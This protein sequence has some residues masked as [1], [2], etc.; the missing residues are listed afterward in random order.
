MFLGFCFWGLCSSC[1]TVS[2]FVDV[3]RIDLQNGASYERYLLDGTSEQIGRMFARSKGVRPSKKLLF[4]AQKIDTRVFIV[5]Y[6][7][8]TCPDC[9]IVV[10]YLERLRN[11]NPQIE[12]R[13]FARDDKARKMLLE[14]TGR[15]RI[16]TV[17]ITDRSG[18]IVSGHYVEYPRIVYDLL[19]KSKTEDERRAYIDDF[20][21]GK[22]DDD[23]QNDL[24]DLID[25]IYK[26]TD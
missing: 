16:P 15:N 18:R 22:Y 21:A 20:R 2:A 19:E 13:Y 6:G 8:I 4:A 5:I 23:V 7:S 11:A 25:S 14:R 1:K 9:A 10:P 26:A 24:A 17:F 12:T 3:D